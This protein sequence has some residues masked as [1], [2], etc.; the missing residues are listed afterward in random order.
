MS[1]Q[2]K[3]GNLLKAPRT[4]VMANKIE[5]FAFFFA[6]LSCVHIE[7]GTKLVIYS[8]NSF[9]ISFK[10]YFMCFN[11]IVTNSKSIIIETLR[12]FNFK[13]AQWGYSKIK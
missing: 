8:Y 2:K 10:L 11:S 6:V 12:N 3:S 9:R 13:I 7:V 1:V 5:N 4:L